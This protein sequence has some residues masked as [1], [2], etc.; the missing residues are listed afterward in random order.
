MR[1]LTSRELTIPHIIDE[2]RESTSR[3]LTLLMV[4]EMKQGSQPVGS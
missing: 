1:E 4:W 2:P 3:K